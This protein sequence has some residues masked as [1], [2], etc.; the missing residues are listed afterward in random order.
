LAPHCAQNFEPAALACP[1]AAQLSA[2]GVPHWGQKRLS[3]GISLPQLGQ[4][5]DEDMGDHIEVLRG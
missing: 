1:Q 3:P 2:C 4:A 5:L